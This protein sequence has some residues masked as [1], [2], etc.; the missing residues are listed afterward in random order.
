MTENFKAVD[1][2][3]AEG[4]RDLFRN[5]QNG[6]FSSS[7]TSDLIRQ[8]FNRSGNHE[9]NF[10][11]ILKAL[12]S[13]E[14]DNHGEVLED[15]KVR[16]SNKI[17]FLEI[18]IPQLLLLE[19]A[20]FVN[21]INIRLKLSKLF[22]EL[23][24]SKLG[25]QFTDYALAKCSDPDLLPALSGVEIVNGYS[26]IFETL[27]KFGLLEKGQA[28]IDEMIWKWDVGVF[29]D[30]RDD[31]PLSLT[32]QIRHGNQVLSRDGLEVITSKIISQANA[33]QIAL[34]LHSGIV[35]NAKGCRYVLCAKLIELANATPI[36]SAERSFVD[37]VQNRFD[38]RHIS[39]LAVDVVSL[40]SMQL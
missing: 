34:F 9:I 37:L 29:E 8:A 25:E 15:L 12:C 31:L 23:D 24:N 1:L 35:D 36:A 19:K 10:D 20:G 22:L 7:E 33:K 11:Q 26:G 30:V 21:N 16:V 14:L 40:A 32:S 6:Y 27:R 13:V 3:S 17:E 4:I 18:S 39:V 28:L 5:I 2:T 38:E